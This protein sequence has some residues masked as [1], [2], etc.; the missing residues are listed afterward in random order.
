MMVEMVCGVLAGAAFGTNVG[1][2]CNPNAVSRT[3]PANLGQ[4][5]V[6]LDL[7]AFTPGYAERLQALVEQ[8]HGLPPADDAGGP[9]LVPGEL[10]QQSSKRQRAEGIELHEN[11]CSSLLRLASKTGVKVP[12]SIAHVDPGLGLLKPSAPEQKDV[13]SV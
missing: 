11:V 6:A 7:D 9:V 13:A 8:M 12:A 5:F 2:A 4:C 1:Q 10:E 3:E